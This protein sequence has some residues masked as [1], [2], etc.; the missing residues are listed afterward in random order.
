MTR[1]ETAIPSHTDMLNMRII[2]PATAAH[3]MMRNGL[4]TRNAVEDDESGHKGHGEPQKG[5][6]PTWIEYGFFGFH[7]NLLSSNIPDKA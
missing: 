7:L 6:Q 1:A 3:A 4:G 2:N 5:S